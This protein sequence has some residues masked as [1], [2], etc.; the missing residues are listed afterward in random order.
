MCVKVRD[1]F[2]KH[3]LLLLQWFNIVALVPGSQANAKNLQEL[4]SLP[5]LTQNIQLNL[6]FNVFEH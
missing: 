4:H 3:C 5:L 2:G 1:Y 6:S